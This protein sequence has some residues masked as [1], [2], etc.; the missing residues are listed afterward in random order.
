[1]GSV[2]T[3]KLLSDAIDRWDRWAGGEMF[4]A[5]RL[6]PRAKARLLADLLEAV[7]V[8]PRCE[9]GVCSEHQSGGGAATV[10]FG[11]PMGAANMFQTQPG[12]PQTAVVSKPKGKKAGA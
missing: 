3:R 4:L 5:E 9:A 11:E 1:M 12:T 7:G 8:C 2:D 10:D 6:H